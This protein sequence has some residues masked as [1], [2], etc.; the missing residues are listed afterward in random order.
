[1]LSDTTT[2]GRESRS[3]A[4]PALGGMPDASEDAGFYGKSSNAARASS[5]RNRFV[6]SDNL[7]YAFSVSRE[8]IER[9]FRS[10][11]SCLRDSLVEKF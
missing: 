9:V 5:A 8:N 4:L 10:F 3:V 2:R 7:A 1:V 11:S 6:F